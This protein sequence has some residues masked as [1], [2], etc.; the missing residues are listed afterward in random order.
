M[1]NRVTVVLIALIA[2][3]AISSTACIAPP[4]EVPC[5]PTVTQINEIRIRNFNNNPLHS[6]SERAEELHNMLSLSLQ[7]REDQRVNISDMVCNT[8]EDEMNSKHG[9]NLNNTACPW[10]YRCNYRSNRYPRYSVEASCTKTFC[11]YPNCPEGATYRKHCLPVRIGTRHLLELVSACTAS[12]SG[13]W[14]RSRPEFVNI[15][16]KCGS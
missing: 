5:A 8:I 15:A 9:T 11:S 2:N 14:V 16:C 10:T 13:T 1:N 3:I 12:D 6:L 4:M 7:S